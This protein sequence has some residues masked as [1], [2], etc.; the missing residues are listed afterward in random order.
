MRFKCYFSISIILKLLQVRILQGYYSKLVKQTH[1]A[2]WH[3][4]PI[5]DFYDDILSFKLILTDTKTDLVSVFDRSNLFNGL[6][7]ISIP[8]HEVELGKNTMTN[9][10]YVGIDV[11]IKSQNFL[12]M[13]DTA[14]SLNF[15]R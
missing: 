4:A 14:S 5:D 12:F 1:T 15:I 10:K 13:V 7:S 8:L 3:T 2:T 11:E 6:R 9:I